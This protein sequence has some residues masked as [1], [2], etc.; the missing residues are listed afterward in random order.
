MP[1][2]ATEIHTRLLKCALEVED[3][4]A[5]W[6]HAAASLAPGAASAAFEQYWFGARSLAR[7]EV[8]LSNMRARFGAFP[9][10]L[11]VLSR[12][13]E[14]TPEIR[15]VVC[16]WHLQLADPLYRAFT[17]DFLATRRAE[18]RPEVTRQVVITWVGH[19]AMSR[20]TLPTR[21]QCASKLLSAA[22]SAGLIAK[23]RDPRPLSLPRVPDVALEYLFY[24]LRHTAFSGSLL[25]NPYARSVGLEGH[26]LESRLGGLPGL[27]FGRQG[28]LVD[29]GFRFADLREW[30][31]A[32]LGPAA[33]EPAR[34]VA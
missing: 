3:C 10:A 11:E 28:D 27:G 19:A 34:G 7:V 26:A 18:G 16:H 33:P 21:I 12:W 1:A 24:L 2:E 9:A 15:R 13:P 30:A 14:M 32:R 29:F 4:R 31:A 23:T 5:Y 6:A 22:H 25:Q 17:G 20:W 8:L